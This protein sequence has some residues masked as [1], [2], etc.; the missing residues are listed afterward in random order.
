VL[1]VGFVPECS[2]MDGDK[3]QHGIIQAWLIP[4]LKSHVVHDA[5]MQIAPEIF[6]TTSRVKKALRRGRVLSFQPT[7]QERPSALV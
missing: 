3:P 6:P 1:L 2:L 7:V 4:A 5:L